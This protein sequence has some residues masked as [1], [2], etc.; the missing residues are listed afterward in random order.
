MDR[1]CLHWKEDTTQGK[2]RDDM[3][4]GPTHDPLKYTFKQLM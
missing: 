2:C 3:G 4:D 1:R